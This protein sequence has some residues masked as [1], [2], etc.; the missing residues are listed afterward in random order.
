M[1]TT[2]L[3]VADVA[4][5]EQTSAPRRELEQLSSE[6]GAKLLRALGVKGQEAELRS[7][8]AEFN[9]HCLALTLLG[10]YLSDAYNGDIRFRGEV[11]GHLAHDLRQGVHA[12]KVMES[13][14]TWLGEGPEV[15]VLRMLGLFDRPA[16]QK[17][18]GAL[19]EPPAIPGLTESL[20]NLS[21]SEWQRIFAKLRRARLLAAED[22]HNPRHLDAHPLVRE[23]FGEQLRTNQT[24]AWKECNRRLY[25]YYRTLA[26]HLP[27]SFN[28]ME[29]LFLS[30]I[31]GCNAGLFRQALHEVYILRIQRGDIYFAA[32]VLGARATLLSVLAHFFKQG[33]WGSLL[34]MGVEEQSLSSEDQLFIFMQAG[35]YLTPREGIKRRRREFVTRARSPCVVPSN[36]RRSCIWR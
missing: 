8:S 1:I 12:Q 11:S 25:E 32:N 18:L 10:S 28:E 13:Y 27:D 3:P 14:Q 36:V 23:Y 9:G 29:P 20:I 15:S 4:D 17:A 22:S 24:Q 7:A 16:D 21:P 34:E 31:C 5:H 35:L 33:Y 19:M 2:R 26:P 6:A 30:V